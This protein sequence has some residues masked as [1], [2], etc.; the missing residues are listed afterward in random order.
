MK[1]NPIT[2]S[3]W[4]NESQFEAR[5]SSHSAKRCFSDPAVLCALIRHQDGFWYRRVGLGTGSSSHVAVAVV[6][7][8]TGA[9][10][11]QRQPTQ[12]STVRCRCRCERVSHS[13]GYKIFSLSAI[14]DIFSHQVSTFLSFNSKV[15]ET[16]TLNFALAN[17]RQLMFCCAQSKCYESDS[18]LCGGSLAYKFADVEGSSVVSNVWRG[19]G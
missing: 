2:G 12:L 4:V 8:V 19:R 11:C 13:V 9:A 14:S 15:N 1:F 16:S 6:F 18:N 10:R 3:M 17:F 5:S 7:T